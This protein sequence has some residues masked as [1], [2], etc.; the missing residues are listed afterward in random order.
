M[1]LDFC[2]ASFIRT[3]IGIRCADGVVMGA[4]KILLSPLLKKGSNKQIA[5]LGPHQGMAFSGWAPDARQLIDRGRSEI[6]N[7]E[8]T[9]DGVIPPAVLAERMAQ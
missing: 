9:Y 5:T 3:A 2:T 7:Y 1:L 8:E 6:S 4:E